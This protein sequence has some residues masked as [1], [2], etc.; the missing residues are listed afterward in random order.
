[1]LN[2]LGLER[3]NVPTSEEFRVHLENRKLLK[4]K[5]INATNIA[6]QKLLM[7][8]NLSSAN[9]DASPVNDYPTV[10]SLFNHDQDATIEQTTPS[11]SDSSVVLTVHLDP[12]ETPLEWSARMKRGSG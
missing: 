2:S 10:P 3:N 8:Y 12:N 11:S 5:I 7:Q 6:T 4:A 9:V 1:M